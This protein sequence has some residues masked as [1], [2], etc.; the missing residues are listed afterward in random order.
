MNIYSHHSFFVLLS[1]FCWDLSAVL[2][3][4]RAFA[5]Q[6]CGDFS[7]ILYLSG[8]LHC[9]LG[10]Q[11]TDNQMCRGKRSCLSVFSN[12][13]KCLRMGDLLLSP[14]QSKNNFLAHLILPVFL[15]DWSK[16][17]SAGWCSTTYVA[18]RNSGP[19]LIPGI[20]RETG[21]NTKI[22]IL[23]VVYPL[24]Q[25][26]SFEIVSIFSTQTAFHT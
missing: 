2:L 22:P 20:S 21:M 25:M 17:C 15:W 18:A 11:W 26:K 3:Y 12:I 6:A 8:L 7:A 1:K 24:P 5:L 4:V 9:K 19:D 10:N 13:W 16:L 14:W 23:P